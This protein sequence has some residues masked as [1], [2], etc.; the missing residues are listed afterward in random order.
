MN[1]TADSHFIIA[2][3]YRLLTVSRVTNYRIITYNENYMINRY[4]RYISDIYCA[5]FVSYGC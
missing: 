2:F 5:Y 4:C 3:L 1:Y